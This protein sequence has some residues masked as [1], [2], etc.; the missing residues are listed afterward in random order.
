[1]VKSSSADSPLT[2][3][4]SHISISEGDKSPPSVSNSG[5]SYSGPFPPKTVSHSSLRVFGTQPTHHSRKKAESSNLVAQIRSSDRVPRSPSA[6][7]SKSSKPKKAL[8]VCLG[9]N[10]AFAVYLILL[11]TW[12]MLESGLRY[13]SSGCLVRRLRTTVFGTTSFTFGRDDRRLPPLF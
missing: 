8:C 13:L 10:K 11:G 1:M 7:V 3:S 5:N 4:P 9:N 2:K 6:P 12:C